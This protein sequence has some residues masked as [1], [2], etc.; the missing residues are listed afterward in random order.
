MDTSVSFICSTFNTP[1]HGTTQRRSFSIISLVHTPNDGL[2]WD[3][4]A[5][6]ANSLK[7]KGFTALWLPP[8]YKGMGGINDVGYGVYD[9][10]DFGEFDQKG[11]VRTKYG[12]NVFGSLPGGVYFYQLNMAGFSKTMKMMLVK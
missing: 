10:F 6:K 11:T 5:K 1:S 2:F 4:L 3:N 7:H 9:L 8:A 12:T